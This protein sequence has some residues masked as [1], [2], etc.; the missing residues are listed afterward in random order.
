MS[1]QYPSPS[2][3]LYNIPSLQEQAQ[4]FTHGVLSPR[5]GPGDIWGF[6]G[7]D[8][9]GYRSVGHLSETDGKE[10]SLGQVRVGHGAALPGLSLSASDLQKSRIHAGAAPEKL[11]QLPYPIFPTSVSP[12]PQVTGHTWDR[13]DGTL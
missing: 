1:P 8:L 5:Q 9:C 13:A 3:A 7:R 11:P 10:K 2:G 12:S 6:L 4:I